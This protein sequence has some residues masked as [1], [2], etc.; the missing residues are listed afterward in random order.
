M[1]VTGGDVAH[2]AASALALGGLCRREG[3]GSC[4]VSTAFHRAPR[5]PGK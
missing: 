1:D 2:A 4:N 5:P 3:Q